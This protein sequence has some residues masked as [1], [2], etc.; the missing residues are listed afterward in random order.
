MEQLALNTTG[1]DPLAY[2]QLT[3]TSDSACDSVGADEMERA[4]DR[5]PASLPKFIVIQ[6]V[7]SDCDELRATERSGTSRTR[8]C[9]QGIMSPLLCR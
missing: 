9:N 3:Q 2:T 1:T 7:E 5:V 6:R 4:A 8:T